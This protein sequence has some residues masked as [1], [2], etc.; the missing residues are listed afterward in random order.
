MTNY[1]LN[2]AHDAFVG[3]KEQDEDGDVEGGV[4]HQ[5]NAAQQRRLLQD[6]AEVADNVSD[7]DDDGREVPSSSSAEED[8]SSSQQQQ[9]Q[10]NKRDFH[11]LKRYINERSFQSAPLQEGNAKQ[12][13]QKTQMGPE[14]A[15]EVDDDGAEE[16]QRWTRTIPSARASL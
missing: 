11:F 12:S 14:E 13:G 10:G 4:C 16:V 15:V 2:K 6:T 8:H 3:E 5:S 9:Q 7:N 1:A